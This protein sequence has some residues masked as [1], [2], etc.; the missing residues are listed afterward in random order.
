ML[1]MDQVRRDCSGSAIFSC[2]LQVD[3]LSCSVDKRGGILGTLGGREDALGI[4]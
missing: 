3:V 4:E 2:K 1:A